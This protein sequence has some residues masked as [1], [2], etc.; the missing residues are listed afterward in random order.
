MCYK[1]HVHF[2]K[3]FD[4][5][6]SETNWQDGYKIVVF[7]PFNIVTVRALSNMKRSIVLDVLYMIK[8]SC[9]YIK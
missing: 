3:I 6:F 2:D 5:I 8:H 4:S 7:K 1:A 9:S